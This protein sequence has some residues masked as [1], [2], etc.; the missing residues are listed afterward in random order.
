M[1]LA[2]APIAY[3]W[4]SAARSL[5]RQVA[6]VLAGTLIL[7]ASSK[8]TVPFWPVP[9]TMQPAAVLLV[10]AL[11]GPSLGAATVITYLFEGALGLPVF[12]GTP[13][14]GIGLPYILGPTGGYL[15][16]YVLAVA[17]AG[18]AAAR[19]GAIRVA[20]GMLLAMLT[21]YALGFAWLAT[22]LGAEQAFWMGVAPFALADAIKVAL[23]SALVIGLR[24]RMRRA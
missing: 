22:I 7:W 13:A 6:L 15:L 12:A 10:G 20:G 2:N 5:M 24:G 11:Y 18:W 16:S 9:L 8:V 21:I 23:V 1:I 17:I 3:L 14:R 4:P 19:V